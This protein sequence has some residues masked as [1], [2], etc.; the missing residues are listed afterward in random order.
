MKRVQEF[1]FRLLRSRSSI[2][3]Y[4]LKAIHEGH[5][6][7]PLPPGITERAAYSKK[8]QVHLLAK[9]CKIPYRIITRLADGAVEIEVY[10]V[11]K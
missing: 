9:R 4:L 5:A 2:A 1:E 11:V 3:P 7:M 8:V 10:E 6:V